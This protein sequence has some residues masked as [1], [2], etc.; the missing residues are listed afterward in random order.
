MLVDWTRLLA[1]EMRIDCLV[2]YN[3]LGFD[4]RYCA[5]RSNRAKAH[6]F[7]RLS[8][9]RGEVVRLDSRTLSSSAMG[10]NE[11]H[12]LP[13]A[14]RFTL[15][16][17]QFVKTRFSSL[18]SLSLDFVSKHFLGNDDDPHQAHRLGQDANGKVAMAYSEITAAFGPVGSAERR[19]KVV[20][21]C[22]QDCDLPMRLLEKLFVLQEVTEM[23]RVCHTQVNDIL[24]RGQ[25][26]RVYS[27]LVIAAHKMGFIANDMAAD[28]FQDS[29]KYVGA[30]VLEPTPGYYDDPVVT[31]DF[32]SLYPNIMRSENLCF[33]S[34]V[35]PGT[36]VPGHIET[37]S[38]QLDAARNIT[39]VK[40]STY[41][42]VLPRILESLL[43][44]RKSTR[45]KLKTLPKG[46]AE[47]GLLDGRQLAYKICCNSVYGFCGANKG[48]YP[49]K[50][51]AEATTFTGRGMIGFT[52]SLFETEFGA[53]IIYGDTD[54]VM[55]VFPLSKAGKTKDQL[56]REA[57]EFGE[58]ASALATARFANHNKLECEKVNQPYMLFGKKTYAGCVYETPDS[59]PKLDVK[60]LAVVRRDTCDFTARIMRDTLNALM[61]DCDVQKARRLV[62][63]AMVDLAENRVGLDELTLSKRLS[64][65]YK[66]EQLPHLAVVRKMQQ[67]APGSEPKSGDRVQFAMV[68]HSDPKAKAFEHSEDV[69]YIRQHG[70]KVDRIFYLEHQIIRPVAQLFHFFKKDPAQMFDGVLHA[71]RRQRAGQRT[72]AGVPA[73][74]FDFDTAWE[75]PVPGGKGRSNTTLDCGVGFGAVPTNQPANKRPANKRPA[76]DKSANQ[77]AIKQRRQTTLI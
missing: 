45:E 22:A 13:M 35:F 59:A 52:K 73:D 11:L 21:Y 33:S 25:Q 16:L 8:K 27:H 12:H 43:A 44:A 64:G 2:G 71:L 15:D 29:E 30:T 72:L 57:F 46:S 10:D 76:N 4:N 51:I 40:S 18:K 54:S 26:I 36:L 68:E 50:V 32:A 74:V 42:G 28:A 5:E 56:I 49:L 67:R 41:K 24:M 61:L 55:A 47:R 70:L 39:F 19:G 66:N 62:G 3:V 63:N 65:S 75:R 38:F 23:A 34:C 20:H 48:M 14:G 60:G 9:L 58:R 7:F 77:P 31:C 53:R 69:N 17:F 37:K 1:R 6:E